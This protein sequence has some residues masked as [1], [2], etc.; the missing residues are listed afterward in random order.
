[1]LR[2]RWRTGIIPVMTPPTPPDIPAG[3]VPLSLDADR[4]LE[5]IAALRRRIQERFPDSGLSNLC[6]RLHEIGERAKNRLAWV[7][8]PIFLLRTAT[9]LMAALVIV[10]AIVL[11][12]SI[13]TG[14]EVS[15]A[16]ELVQIIESGIQD[17]VFVGLGL[18]FLVTA[19]NRIKRTR[20]LGFIKELRAVA[21]IVDMHQLTKDPDRLVGEH[22][23]DTASSPARSYTRVELGRYLDYC[24][25]MLSLT[26]KIAALFAERID[27]AVILQ[28]VDEVETL[29]TNLSGKIWQKIMI[30]DAPE[31]FGGEKKASDPG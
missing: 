18:F 25:E 30:L 23:V 22:R 19:E 6:E 21:H 14:L 1:M 24:S 29:T 13:V 5:T 12:Q 16:A 9:W 11:I 31:L 10:G 4:I 17:L 28:A 8:Q 15:G 7:E 20:A 27:D 2:P 26:A 3:S